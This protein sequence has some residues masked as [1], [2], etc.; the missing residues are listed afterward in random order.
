MVSGSRVPGTTPRIAAR[1]AAVLLALG[2]PASSSSQSLR[3]NLWATN[4]PVNA[5]TMYNNVLYVGGG[6]SRVGPVVGRA[7]AI[8]AITGKVLER[9]PL[10][11]MDV[12]DIAPDGN[13]GYY[14]CGAFSG[15]QGYVRNQIAH[16]DS[17]GKLTSWFPNIVG[18]VKRMAVA[19]NVVY[20]AGDITAADDQPREGVAAI[21][22]VTGMA[23]SWAPTFGLTG[24]VNALAVSGGTVYLGGTFTSVNGVSRHHLAA[25]DAVTGS[26]TAW[27][28]NPNGSNVAVLATRSGLVFAG[29]DFTSVDVQARTAL[30][31]IDSMSG[32]A[33]PF[34]AQ[35]QGLGV[36]N[37]EW[38]AGVLYVCGDFGAAGGQSRSGLAAVDATTGALMP[39]NPSPNGVVYDLAAGSGG[40]YVC[41]TFTT[42]GGQSREKIAALDTNGN[43]T[44]WTVLF[45]PYREVLRLASSGPTVYA[46]GTFVSMG[47]VLRNNLAAF[48]PV[49]GAALPWDPSASDEVRALRVVGNLVY[50]GGDFM[51]VHG[52]T[53]NH[54]VA[55]D[56]VSGIP[57]TFAVSVNAPVYSLASL[58]TTLYVGGLFQLVGGLSR[59]NL[60]SIDLT[61]ST[62]TGWNPYP[63]NTV[64]AI[65]PVTNQFG[66]VTVYIGGDFTWVNGSNGPSREHIALIDGSGAALPWDPSLNDAVYALA[67]AVGS[68]GAVTVYAGGA[69]DL[70][71][72]A[73]TREH[74]VAIDGNGAATSWSA[75]TNGRVDALAFGPNNALYASGGFSTIRG[76]YRPGVGC[77]DRSSGAVTNWYYYF[78]GEPYSVLPVGSTIYIGGDFSIEEH[79][80][81]AGLSDGTVTAV[82]T[83]SPESPPSIRAA[84]N[85]FRTDSALRFSLP[86]PEVAEV[87]IY[88][89]AGRLVRRVYRGLLEQGSHSLS[90]DGRNQIG[91]AVASG[92]YLMRVRTP[93]LE[94]R[95]KIFRLK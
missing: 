72:G 83:Q 28:P 9:Y 62:T 87:A 10:A 23:T 33:T 46:A 80:D 45:E 49:S 90:W 7:A 36:S 77:I 48:D 68:R 89:A 29:G 43:A 66:F 61:T 56:P 13:G 8:D 44:G 21:D 91:T 31:A 75:D 65:A 24:S 4:G 82:E 2:V 86:Q 39:W 88:D 52:V 6:F 60:A 54:L 58:G 70:V 93:S 59:N 94:L 3:G 16:L 5:M 35:I 84:P 20:V 85:P 81:L 11:N 17:T 40:I 42:I 79:R 50:A 18:R 57:G 74:L 22:R 27:N 19:T 15:V 30:A 95:G 76:F 37:F 14:I 64:R 73:T 67:V 25:V 32:A 38:S 92:L 51:T 78:S 47:Q 71:G 26:L 63:G 34:D 53:R 69:F 55:V 1:L 12:D 41:G